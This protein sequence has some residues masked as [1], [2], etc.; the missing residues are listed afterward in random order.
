VAEI[1]MEEMNDEEEFEEDKII[2]RYLI[3]LIHKAD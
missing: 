3:S 2:A 1:R